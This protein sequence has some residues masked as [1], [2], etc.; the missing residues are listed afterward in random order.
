ML[1]DSQYILVAP[2]KWKAGTHLENSIEKVSTTNSENEEGKALS[3]TDI[4][5]P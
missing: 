5:P 4:N 2:Q 1:A 3:W